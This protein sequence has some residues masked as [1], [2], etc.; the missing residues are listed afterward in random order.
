[1][2]LKSTTHKDYRLY[3]GRTISVDYVPYGTKRIVT[4][5]LI[6]VMNNGHFCYYI[7]VQEKERADVFDDTHLGSVKRNT[8]GRCDVD[9]VGPLD[10]LATWIPIDKCTNVIIHPS[11]LTSGKSLLWLGI[12]LLFKM[13]K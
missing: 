8:N 6:A 4:G 13:L 2:K 11:Q 7:A 3:L 10:A 1:M 5:R 12:P 9:Y